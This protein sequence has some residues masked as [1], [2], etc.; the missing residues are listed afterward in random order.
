MTICA[1][2]RCGVARW[3][4]VLAAR[5]GKIRRTRDKGND[6]LCGFAS[7]MWRKRRACR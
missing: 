4:A 5:S 2:R 6:R 1:R 7:R 3:M